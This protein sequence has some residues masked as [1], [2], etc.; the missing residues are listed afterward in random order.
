MLYQVIDGL[1]LDLVHVPILKDFESGLKQLEWRE[2]SIP[3]LL[4]AQQSQRLWVTAGLGQS[5][6]VN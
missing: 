6:G 2:A 5:H 1:V 4:E 3:G